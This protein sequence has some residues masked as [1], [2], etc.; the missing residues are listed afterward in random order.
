MI[1]T[2]LMNRF[3]EMGSAGIFGGVTGVIFQ[4]FFDK[5]V[6]AITVIISILIVFIGINLVGIFF[7]WLESKGPRKK[8]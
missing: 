7:D 8:K 4:A 6:D 3:M 2:T 1:S 5:K